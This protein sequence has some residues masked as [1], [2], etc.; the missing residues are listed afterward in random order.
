ME[1]PVILSSP[2][3]KGKSQREIVQ[4][5][6]VPRRTVRRILK[7]EHTAESVKRSTRNLI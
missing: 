5:T 2:L 4:E 1:T 3:E 7:L 6:Q